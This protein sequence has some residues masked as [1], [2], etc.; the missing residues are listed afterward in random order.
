MQTLIIPDIHEEIAK[1]YNIEEL[2]FHQADRVVLVGDLFDTFQPYDKGRVRNIV[3]WIKGHPD[4]EACWGNHD[5]HYAFKHPWFKCSGW[6]QRRQNL[7]DELMSEQ[8]WRRMFHPFLQVGKFIVSHAGFHPLKLGYLDAKVAADSVDLAFKGE[9]NG[10]WN[11]GE[12]VGGKGIGGPTWLRWDSV[13]SPTDT[14]Q[15]LDVPQIVGH[16][17]SWPDHCV[18]V[19]THLESGTKSYCIDTSMRS[20]IW[21]DGSDIEIVQV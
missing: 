11:P 13:Q 15:P 9:F 6:Q 7:L 18:R 14:F 1:L 8:D 16:T 2:Y 5:C 4:V 3:R 10:F 20:V 19:K 17:P 12:S 21:T